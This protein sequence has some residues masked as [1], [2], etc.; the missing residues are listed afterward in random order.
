MGAAPAHKS[1]V[2]GLSLSRVSP[3]PSLQVR[4]GSAVNKFLGWLIEKMAEVGTRS[5]M[6]SNHEIIY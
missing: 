5:S 2:E 4:K 3:L 6:T 1:V